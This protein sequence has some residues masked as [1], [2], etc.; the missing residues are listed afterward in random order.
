MPALATMTS[1]RPN[2]VTIVLTIASTW[3]ASLTS[4]SIATD[5]RP[6]ARISSTTASASGRIAGG[7]R[8]RR[9]ARRPQGVRRCLARS[10]GGAGD[11][12]CSRDGMPVH[13]AVPPW[14]SE[15]HAQ[16][17]AI[18]LWHAK[19]C[20]Q[21]AGETPAPDRPQA[22]CS[23][24]TREAITGPCGSC[25]AALGTK[26][27]IATGSSRPD[28]FWSHVHSCS[29]VPA[30]AAR[31][32]ASLK[33]VASLP[34]PRR[35]RTGRQRPVVE[36]ERAVRVVGREQGSTVGRAIGRDRHVLPG[37]L[38]RRDISAR[39]ETRSPL[40]PYKC[41]VSCSR[42]TPG[43]H[44]RRGSLRAAGSARAGR[45]SAPRGDAGPAGG[46]MGGLL[47]PMEGDIR[48][49]W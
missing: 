4:T 20:H 33:L 13:R 37:S 3:P 14:R 12:C 8:R 32:S 44:R 16:L 11:Q 28:S 26:S 38:R 34:H 15:L 42:V 19:G 1:S 10:P 29:V 48:S 46:G 7:R 6:V 27:P 36:G 25:A 43:L 39:V 9:Q 35:I 40:S 18:T 45:R 24:R 2:S 21:V 5:C 41:G 47:D 30:R 49:V 31:C 17:A 23:E 22:R